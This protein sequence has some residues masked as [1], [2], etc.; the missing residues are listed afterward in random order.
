LKRTDNLR[1][2]DVFGSYAGGSLRGWRERKGLPKK[3]R[4]GTRT[5]SYPLQTEGR[6]VGGGL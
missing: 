4:G 6:E 5:I 2:V 1:N 3:V